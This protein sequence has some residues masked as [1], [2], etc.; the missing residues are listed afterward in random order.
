MADTDLALLLDRFMRRIHAALHAKA[1]DFDSDRIGPG[2]AMVLLTLADME[3]A[4][5]HELARRVARD[6]SQMTRVVQALETK[7]MVTRKPAPQDARVSLISLTDR[8]HTVVATLRQ[9]LAETIDEILGPIA[10]QEK[11]TLRDLLRR[12]MS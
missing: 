7:G 9:V 8:G 11:R 10:E 4:Q 12:A 5:M 1:P 3:T 2:G 6:K